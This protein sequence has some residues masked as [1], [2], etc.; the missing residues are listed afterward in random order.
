MTPKALIIAI[1]LILII[2]SATVI[3]SYISRFGFVKIGPHS[4]RFVL[5]CALSLSLICGWRPGRWITIVLTGRGGVGA[6]VGGVSLISSGHSGIGLIA[7]GSIY[8]VCII[9]LLTPFAGRHFSPNRTAEHD[10]GL[11]GLQP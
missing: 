9:S 11:K 2:C 7:L 5:T 8:L 3:A 1:A 6:L 4:V 10:V